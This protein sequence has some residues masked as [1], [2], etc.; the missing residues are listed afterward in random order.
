VASTFG[1]Q[2]P[3]TYYHEEKVYENDFIDHSFWY[4]FGSM[5]VS[6]ACIPDSAWLFAAQRDYNAAWNEFLSRFVLQMRYDRT[7]DFSEEDLEALGRAGLSDADIAGVTNPAATPKDTPAQSP[8]DGTVLIPTNDG[9][10]TRYD[11]ELT[12]YINDLSYQNAQVAMEYGKRGEVKR[13][14]TYGTERIAATDVTGEVD[15]YLYDG[16]GSVSQVLSMP[17]AGGRTTGAQDIQSFTYDPYGAVTSD[18]DP[19]DLVFAYNAEEYNPVTGLQY[20]RARYYAPDTANFITRDGYL[21]RATSINSQNRYGFAESDPVNN[22]DPSGHTVG[23][24]SYERQMEGA[25]GI[26]EIYNLYVGTTLQNSYNRASSAFYSKLNYAYGVDHTSQAAINSITGISQATAN[27]YID[28]GAAAAMAAGRSWGCTP[29]DLTK[30]AINT[31]ATNVNATRVSVNS[32][33]SAVKAN[34]QSQFYAYQAYLAYLAE[35]QRL[36]EEA[37]QKALARTIQANANMQGY[38]SFQLQQRTEKAVVAARGALSGAIGSLFKKTAGI[39]LKQI[40]ATPV[41]AV[42]IHTLKPVDRGGG[43]AP[44]AHVIL[45][46]LGL[47][48]VVGEAFDVI[49]GIWYAAEGDWLNAGLSFGSAIPFAGYAATGT[50]LGIRF[51]K[52]LGGETLEAGVKQADNIAESAGRGLKSVENK[53]PDNN[54]Q[55]GH[56]FR[57]DD[58]H[59]ADT[60]ANRKLLEN[61]ANDE[62]NYLGKDMFG[63][64]W[65]A[66]TRGDGTQVWVEA[67]NGTIID[68]GINTSPRPWDSLTGLKAP[69]P[70]RQ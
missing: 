34:K 48:P 56:I 29:G 63:N 33:I 67:R 53:I 66:Q 24:T 39:P 32:R 13:S 22:A 8:L 10:D 3:Q 18:I 2:T 1:A 31:F 51:G 69:A 19:Y 68:G 37:Y 14:Y 11:Y 47:I 7:D 40:A 35:R 15:T 57:K 6:A 54:S 46:F 30:A 62:R 4:G 60:P 23:K 64:G 28:S 26:N 41:E 36:A 21:G 12:Y 65:Y 38:K 25:G 44:S 55:T 61:T 27:Y 20:L 59:I 45:D 58:G 5:L 49:N 70:P 9:A 16:R 52:E 50:K 43:P 17:G 42:N